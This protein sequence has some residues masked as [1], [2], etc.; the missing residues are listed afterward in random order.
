MNVLHEPLFS[1]KLNHKNL[2]TLIYTYLGDWI[3]RQTQDVTNGVDGAEERLSAS[4]PLKRNWR[5]SSK[6]KPLTTF[7]FGGSQL[8][9]NQSAGIPT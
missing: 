8:K 9:N 2:E 4:E 1:Y 3:Y 7:S 6:A 5:W